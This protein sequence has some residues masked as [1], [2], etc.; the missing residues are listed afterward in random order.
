MYRQNTGNTLEFKNNHILNYEVETIA[1]IK[2]DCFVNYWDC[3]LALK[4]QAS[5]VE[6]VA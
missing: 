4:V 3:D 2:R 1:T 6:F 5:E